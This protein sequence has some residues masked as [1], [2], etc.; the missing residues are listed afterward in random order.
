MALYYSYDA[1]DLRPFKPDSLSLLRLEW[2]PS[3]WIAM[4][5]ISKDGFRHR[6]V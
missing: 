3:E 5:A 1:D 4:K 6:R 2:L